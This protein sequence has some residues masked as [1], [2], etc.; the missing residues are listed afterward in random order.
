MR[1]C[2][3]PSAMSSF[4]IDL[5]L[6]FF[7]LSF[8]LFSTHLMHIFSCTSPNSLP[9]TF[10]TVVD[11]MRLISFTCNA[12]YNSVWPYKIYSIQWV[13]VSSCSVVDLSIHI[14]HVDFFFFFKTIWSKQFG[15]VQVC[16]H[17]SFFIDTVKECIKYKF[18]IHNKY[19]GFFL[20]LSFKKK[21]GKPYHK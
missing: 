15:Y 13:V 20:L 21:I 8:L 12:T 4:A 17:T 7:S 16:W 10:T 14:V 2:I 18:I 6:V 11:A 9:S 5:A 1:S 19:F 3:F